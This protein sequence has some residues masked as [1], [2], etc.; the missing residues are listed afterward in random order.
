MLSNERGRC[1]NA[2]SYEY[3]ILRAH[4]M[5]E[6]HTIFIAAG[7]NVQEQGEIIAPVRIVD[8]APTIAEILGFTP[9]PTVQGKIIPNF[10]QP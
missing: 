5:P 2:A 10:I 4:E 3:R 8:Y 9:A 7:A 6:M 1:V